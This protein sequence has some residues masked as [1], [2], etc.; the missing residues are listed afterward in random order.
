MLKPQNLGFTPCRLGSN[1][2]FL[3]YQEFLCQKHNKSSVFCFN[4]NLVTISK[5][6]GSF[7]YI[8]GSFCSSLW[9]PV[10]QQVGIQIGSVFQQDLQVVCFHHLGV[11][12]AKNCLNIHRNTCKLSQSFCGSENRFLLHFLK[13]LNGKN[14]GEKLSLILKAL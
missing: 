14:K 3:F 13:R 7:V 5:C 6:F 11:L 8:L 2:Y 9:F 1:V 4:L 10:V 12:L